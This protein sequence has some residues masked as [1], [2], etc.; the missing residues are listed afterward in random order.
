MTGFEEYIPFYPAWNF[1]WLF[2]I[3]LYWANEFF[4]W[5]MPLLRNKLTWLPLYVTVAS[6]LVYN[7]RWKGLGVLLVAAMCV[8]ACNHISAE[9]MKPYYGQ[10]RPCN[11]SVI[12]DHIVVRVHCGPGKSFPSAHATNHFGMAAFFSLFFL[13]VR[14][15]VI[16][17]LMIWALSISYA[18]VY[19]GVHYPFDV[20]MGAAIGIV[21]G[22]PFGLIGCKILALNSD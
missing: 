10:D 17:L 2:R 20:V 22:I 1:E 15:W 3:N 21:C 5:L 12:K 14:K 13:K 16:A 8:G 6:Y 11:Q 7:F 18:Q 19:V 9:W 4:D